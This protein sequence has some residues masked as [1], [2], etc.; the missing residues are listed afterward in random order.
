MA[1]F[2]VVKVTLLAA[3]GLSA[4]PF[5]RPDM[6]FT[7]VT[8]RVYLVAGRNGVFAPAGTVGSMKMICW[9]APL[10]TVMAP[11][12]SGSAAPEAGVS[13]IDPSEAGFTGAWNSTL[14]KC[15][16]DAS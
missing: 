9:F 12:G 4:R 16:P 7:P 1:K 6:V 11:A 14:R 13:V 8:L 5:G 3:I 10:A 15:A 2:A